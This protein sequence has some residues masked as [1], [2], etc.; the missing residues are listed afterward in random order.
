[1]KSIQSSEL[2]FYG[3]TQSD[4]YDPM[5]IIFSSSK[6]FFLGKGDKSLDAA[7]FVDDFG[8][9]IS[10]SE[11]TIILLS[12][13]LLLD[14]LFESLLVLLQELLSATGLPVTTNVNCSTILH[15]N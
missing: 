3:L 4:N 7:K 10:D 15:P 9:E 2:G 11:D 1:M 5:I 12:S 8:V 14:S 6:C 13:I